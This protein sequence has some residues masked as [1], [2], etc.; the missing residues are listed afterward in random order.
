[1]SEEELNSGLTVDMLYRFCLAA[2]RLGY[3]DR[4]VLVSDDDECNGFHALWSGFEA[5]ASEID[6]WKTLCYSLT[7]F[8]DKDYIL[9]M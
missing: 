7:N 8:E 1:M 6:A 5:S 9:L 2:R 4:L 3:G